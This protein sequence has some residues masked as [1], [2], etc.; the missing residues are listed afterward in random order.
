MSFPKSSDYHTYYL[1]LAETK[2]LEEAANRSTQYLKR[3]KVAMT[4]QEELDQIWK[5]IAKRVKCDFETIMPT[6][7]PNP[8]AFRAVPLSSPE[9][10]SAS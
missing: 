3:A 9:E 8:L 10:K 4:P 5:R 1:T 7:P 2:E 6:D